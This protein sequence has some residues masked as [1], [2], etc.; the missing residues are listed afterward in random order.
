MRAAR[1]YLTSD[2]MTTDCSGASCADH[3]VRECAHCGDLTDLRCFDCAVEAFADAARGANGRYFRE[4][5]AYMPVCPCCR[6]E[7][8]MAH[9]GELPAERLVY[10]CVSR[11]A[12]PTRAERA[13]G[14]IGAA[15]KNP[16]ATT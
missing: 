10:G 15:P 11:N 13:R 1:I 6:V 9:L 4:F 16:E 2:E 12:T 7:H 3:P 5:S 14:R 8:E